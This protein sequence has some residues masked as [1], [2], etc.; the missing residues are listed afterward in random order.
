MA[1]VE[2]K[3]NNA[4]IASLNDS[5]TEVLETNGTYLTDD[6][7]VEYTKSGGGG[8]GVLVVHMVYDGETDNEYTDKTWKEIFDAPMAVIADE[9]SIGGSTT[10]R[11]FPISTVSNNQGE[12][13]VT[14]YPMNNSMHGG[15]TV[16]ETKLV[17]DSENGY[18]T[19]DE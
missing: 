5:G 15:V 3:Y 2:I 6:I 17:T 7:T 11:V 10:K 13:K 18:L 1:D 9:V 14:Y 4:T 19:Y 12:Y 16:E 8:G